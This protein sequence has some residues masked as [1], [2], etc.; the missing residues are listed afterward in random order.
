MSKILLIEYLNFNVS[1]SVIQESINNGG[2][3]I[4]SG[5]VQRAEQVNHNKRRYK[6]QIL[7]REV[8]KY[9][10]LVRERR[11]VGELDHPERSVINL[12]N[13]SHLITDLRWNGNDL[14]GTIEIL[15]TPSGN[16]LREL[17]KCGV[18]VGISSR[19]LG[20]TVDAGDGIQDVD[21]DFEIL[22]WDMVS[23]PSTRGS[24]VSVMT[25]GVQ[26][27]IDKYEKINKTIVNIFES[28]NYDCGS[29][30]EIKI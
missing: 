7:E 14:I 22:G 2:K 28:L 13:V 10:Q 25:E 15:T 23:N 3:L 24:F 1:P 17:F 19:G 18:T 4:V 20:S 27:T 6:K 12:A 16:I 5:I 21:D 9:M 30:C 29:K 11:A 26:H 8:N